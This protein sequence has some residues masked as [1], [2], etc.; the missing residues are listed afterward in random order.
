LI[1]RRNKQLHIPVVIGSTS[2]SELQFRRVLN[3]LRENKIMVITKK[4]GIYIRLVGDV[5]K[6]EC[7]MDNFV[8]VVDC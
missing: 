6:G 1:K 7:W 3:T 5:N 2:D 4:D 8:K